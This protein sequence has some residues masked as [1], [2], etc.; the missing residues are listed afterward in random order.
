MC[1]WLAAFKQKTI[2]KV[3]TVRRTEIEGCGIAK[4][5]T[6]GIHCAS[7]VTA[8]HEWMHEINVLRKHRDFKHQR[9]R[10]TNCLV[11]LRM[12][13]WLNPPSQ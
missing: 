13:Q 10:L 3:A 7:S 9:K 8:S 4:K 11:R 5:R 2:V 12:I 6:L 1:I